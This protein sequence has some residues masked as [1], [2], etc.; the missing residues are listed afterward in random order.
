[1]KISAVLITRNA[2]SDLAQCLASLDFVDE[3][4]VLDQNSIDETLAIC[5]RYGAIVHQQ[6]EWLGFGKMKNSAVTFCAN[7][8][9]LSIDADEVVTPELKQAILDLPDEPPVAAYAVN[10]LSRFLGQWIRFCG[11]HPDWV[12]RLFDRER[13]RFNE[14]AVHEA[15]QTEGDT[16]RL[17]GLLLHYTYNSMEQYIQKLNH[18]TTLAAEEAVA[19]GKRGSIF[20]AV[21]RA[22]AAFF[23]MFFLKSGF[24]DGWHGLLLCL[25]SAFYVLTKYVKIWRAV[26][27]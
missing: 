11:W 22:N 25:C 17:N 14:R 5:E 1:M 19:A 21:V 10:R 12:I 7:R 27:S 15:V 16:G 13:A 3:I 23:R 20:G 8:W 24:R 18:Y 4:V 9:V 26:R 6:N 2:A